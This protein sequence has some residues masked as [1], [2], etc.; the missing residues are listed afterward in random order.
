[1]KNNN[2]LVITVYDE[3]IE[4]PIVKVYENFGRKVQISPDRGLLTSV[5]RRSLF[6]SEIV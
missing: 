5:Q 1:M 3:T 4:I 6:G 2:G